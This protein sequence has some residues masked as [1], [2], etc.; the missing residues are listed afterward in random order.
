MAIRLKNGTT[1]TGLNMKPVVVADGA[2]YSVQA[3]Q[4]GR[5]HVL[6][7]LTADITI[8]LPQVEN[9]L[10][11]EFVYAGAA[12]DAQDWIINTYATTELFKG[13]VVHIDHDAG[14]GGDEAV[15]VFADF[16]ND[17]TFTV[18]TPSAGTWVKI[19]SDG[20]SW[21]ITGYVVSATAPT[22]A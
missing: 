15:P 14:A 12:A 6:P 5:V 4:T 18:L 19:W 1:F 16:S 10:F 21:Y 8:T 13:G 2:T 11:Y 17:D 22:F 7:N 20:T 9:G 3:S